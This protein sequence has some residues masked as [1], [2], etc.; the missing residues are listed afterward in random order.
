MKKLVAVIALSLVSISASFA[1][2]NPQLFKEIN[3]KLKVDISKVDLSNS[4]KNFVIVKF[5]IVNGEIE[6]LG[7]EGSDELRAM[8]VAE[9]EEM[10]I[11][12]SADCDKIYRYK[13]NFQQEV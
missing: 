6:I 13:F 10:F 9:L 8:I 7:A 11:T 1:G 5:R 2:D 12:S 4:S 3:R